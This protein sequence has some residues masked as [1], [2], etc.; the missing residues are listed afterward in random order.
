MKVHPEQKLIKF[1][2][3]Q[4]G[5]SIVKTVWLMVFINDGEHIEES[6]PNTN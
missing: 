2:K 5:E 4:S 1:N 6:L 3:V